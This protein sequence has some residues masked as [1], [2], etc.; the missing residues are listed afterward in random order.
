MPYPPIPEEL[1]REIEDS[2]RR[3]MFYVHTQQYPQA[4]QVAS[5]ALDKMLACQEATGKRVH[6]GWALHNIGNALLVQGRIDEALTCF[7]KA[8]IEDLLS[9]DNQDEADATPAGR[10]LLLIY[11]LSPELLKPL[12]QTVKELK[13]RGRIP[14]DPT[15]VLEELH[16][17]RP[18]YEKDVKEKKTKPAEHPVRKFMSLE[19][20]WNTR[21]FIGGSSEPVINA[22][23]ELVDGIGGYDPVVATDFTTPDDISIYNKCI[24]L[25]HCC[26]YAIFDL[27]PPGGQ[28]I[29]IERAPDYGVATLAVCPADKEHHITAMLKSCLEDRQ[30]QYKSY[31]EFPELEDIFREFLKES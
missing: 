31:R 11:K 26:K 17:W 28:M 6:K 9:A 18:T 10:T 12:K 29:E 20:D 15:K 4:H 2:A 24:A 1:Q 19:T 22:I 8:Y 5:E 23:R 13:I 25:L 14:I 3:Y 16:R 7:I 21:V 30:I 27:W